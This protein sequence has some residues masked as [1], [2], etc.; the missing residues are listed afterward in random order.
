MSSW[1]TSQTDDRQTTWI[2]DYRKAR[3]RRRTR[4]LGQMHP[5]L[6]AQALARARRLQS[7]FYGMELFSHRPQGDAKG[8][9]A[10]APDPDDVLTDPQYGFR[11]PLRKTNPSVAECGVH[12]VGRPVHLHR[13][14]A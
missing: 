1:R 8:K 13:V 14:C 5:S 6:F 4:W 11:R 7:I 9:E 3:C 12:R 10:A 2:I